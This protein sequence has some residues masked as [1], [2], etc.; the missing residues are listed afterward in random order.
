MARKKD[1]IKLPDKLFTIVEVELEIQRIAGG[2]PGLSIN[3]FGEPIETRFQNNIFRRKENGTRILFE[4]KHVKGLLKEVVRILG[5][6]T[7][8]KGILFKIRHSLAMEPSEI[9]IPPGTEVYGRPIP[10]LL[11]NRVSITF[12]EVIEK[13]LRVKF[14]LKIPNGPDGPVVSPELLRKLFE[15]GQTV[16]IGAKRSLGYGKYKV[17]KFEVIT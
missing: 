3:Q 2:E 4:E 14:R 6:S 7:K 12:T 8:E 11:G 17:V 5:L 10:V 1:K 16:G 9:L 13:P 15:V